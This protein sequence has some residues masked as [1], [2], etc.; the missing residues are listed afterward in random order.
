MLMSYSN[1]DLEQVCNRAL[2][3]ITSDLRTVCKADTYNNLG[4]TL[5]RR[6]QIGVTKT[7]VFVGSSYFVRLV[8]LSP[9]LKFLENQAIHS[10][11]FFFQLGFI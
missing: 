7:L 1:A 11:Q 10:S 8:S 3:R 5:D 9:L 2:L 6:P 4:K